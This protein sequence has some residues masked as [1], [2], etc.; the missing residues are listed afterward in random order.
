M[1]TPTTPF[2]KP[3]ELPTQEYEEFDPSAVLALASAGVSMVLQQHILA[4]LSLFFS[5]TSIVNNS[6]RIGRSSS[7]SP[8]QGLMFS[9][10]ALTTL[11]TKRLIDPTVL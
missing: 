8:L 5:I 4:W 10:L 7:T 2:I 9:V 11:Y 3:F 1:T 6:N